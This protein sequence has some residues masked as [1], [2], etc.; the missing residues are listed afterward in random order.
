[1]RVQLNDTSV[2]ADNPDTALTPSELDETS[3][4]YQH[5]ERCACFRRHPT[6]KGEGMKRILTTSWGFAFVL[7]AG[8]SFVAEP[9]LAHHGRGNTYDTSRQVEIDGTITE[10]LWRNPHISIFVDVTDDDG[11]VTNWRIEHSPIHRLAQ[12]GYNRNTLKP[13]ME[14]TVIINPGTDGVPVGL[15]FGVILED[16]TLIMNLRGRGRGAE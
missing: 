14:V 5:H 16:G 8:V 3:V 9:L 15:C 1:M 7:V 13:G 12:Q 2:S 11:L 4:Q 6:R 10:V